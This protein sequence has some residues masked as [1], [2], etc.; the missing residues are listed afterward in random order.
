MQGILTFIQGEL[1]DVSMVT[2]SRIRV[3]S[4]NPPKVQDKRLEEENMKFEVQVKRLEE[5]NRKLHEEN[6]KFEGC[7]NHWR[8]GKKKHK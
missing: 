5:E 7:G 8:V 2:N 6:Q 4:V 3:P 1:A